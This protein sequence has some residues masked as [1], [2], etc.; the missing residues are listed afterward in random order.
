[1]EADSDGAEVE[2]M[3]RV[4]VVVVIAVTHRHECGQEVLRSWATSPLLREVGHNDSSVYKFGM[5]CLCSL[6]PKTP[7]VLI[8]SICS[9]RYHNAYIKNNNK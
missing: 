1:M 3:P 2:E 5:H 9:L 6:R 4:V 7:Q 8:H